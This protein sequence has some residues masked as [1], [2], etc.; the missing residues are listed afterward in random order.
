VSEE[1]NPADP[2]DMD[3]ETAQT[4]LSEFM[5][6]WFDPEYERRVAAGQMAPSTKI[7]AAQAVFGEG[8][9]I[10]RFNEEVRG[11]GFARARRAVQEG[12]QVLHGDLVGIENWEL[13]P[14]EVD[15][16]HMSIFNTG[17]GWRCFFNFLRGRARADALAIRAENF[18]KAARHA[19]ENGWHD[20]S[21]DTLFSACELL[22][23]ANLIVHMQ[24]G[25][26]AKTHPSIHTSINQWKRLGN[27]EAEF[28]KL[29]NDLGN[30]RHIARYEV[31]NVSRL[32]QPSSAFNTVA[33]QVDAVRDLCD[34][35]LTPERRSPTRVNAILA[36][37]EK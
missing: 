1:G 21:V 9:T 37:P 27:I 17:D 33:A 22:A 29:F 23:K 3:A 31:G 32:E 2:G 10:I 14:D 26:E 34:R 15:Y 6:L 19:H 30:L 20:V 36:G 12:E 35:R 7:V 16:G 5:R 18:L 11:Q 13:A 4:A 25:A 28:V 24:K 8:Q